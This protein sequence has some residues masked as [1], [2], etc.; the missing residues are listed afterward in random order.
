MGMALGRRRKQV[1][2]EPQSADERPMLCNDMGKLMDRETAVADKHDV[3]PWQ[4]AAELEC[5]LP[6]SISQQLEQ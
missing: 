5:A 3:S 2:V 4:P 1:G 6:G